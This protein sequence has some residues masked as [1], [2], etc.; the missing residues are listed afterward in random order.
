[1]AHIQT[2]Y[3]GLW[4]PQDLTVDKINS[5]KMFVDNIDAIDDFAKITMQKMHQPV[6]TLNNL[7]SINTSNTETFTTGMLI[8]VREIGMFVFDRSATGGTG[9]DGNAIVAPIT[10]GGAWVPTTPS[11]I[12][13][14]P[15]TVT[16]EAAL[17]TMLTNLVNNMS[18]N[19][20]KFTIING[21]SGIAPLYG[22]TGHITIYKTN[23][24][25]VTV[26]MITYNADKITRQY[27]RTMFGG[28]WGRW[29]SLPFLGQD[30]KIPLD[31]LPSGIMSASVE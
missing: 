18:D 8:M 23:S 22:G 3:V 27:T 7:R 20:I 10:G 17:D 25:Y 16:T 6:Q 31:Q 9:S 12:P 15:K 11:D 14:S 13:L 19:T 21:L 5:Q 26:T 28:A 30:G 4:K 29:I 2:Q 1:M 24:S